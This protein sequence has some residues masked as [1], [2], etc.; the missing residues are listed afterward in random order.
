MPTQKPVL[1]KENSIIDY[2]DFSPVQPHN[3]AVT[4]SV[5]IQ[6][7]NPITT[8]L[9]STLSKFQKNAYGGTFVKD[10]QMVLCGD[11]E[12]CVKLF[13]TS[14]KENLRTFKGH[15]AGVHRAFFTL[16]KKHIASFSDDKSVRLW[17]VESA[18][19]VTKFNDAHT[20][21]IRAG[22]VSPVSPDILLSGGY[23]DI[24][25]MYD[26]R[27]NST[28]FE[29]NHGSRIHSVMFLPTGGIFISCGA[30]HVKLWDAFAGGRL[31][32]VMATHSKDI[33]CVRLACHGR[34]LLSGG[35]DRKVK[36]YDTSTYQ[37]V[38]SLDFPNGITSMA[39]APD[40]ETLVVGMT[41][42][43]VSVQRMDSDRK[44]KTLERKAPKFESPREQI[45]EDHKP[46]VEAQYNKNLRKYCY[47]EALDDV[48]N[49]LCTNRTPHITVG[50]MAELIRRKGLERALKG[51][52]DEFLIKFIAFVIRYIGDSR[53]IKTLINVANVMLDAYENEISNLSA[54]IAKK[55]NELSKALRREQNL[56]IECMELQGAFGM[57]YSGASVAEPS[58]QMM[59]Y[60]RELNQMQP[61]E[62]A[63]EELIVRVDE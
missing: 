34:R 53:F 60:K 59:N 3:F 10:G 44:I 40:D 20:D 1:I 6:I 4:C 35:L 5:R 63:K 33:T 46:T 9:T 41:D 37:T 27:T 39:I 42:G 50:V 23:D 30:S 62:S 31:M 25:K 11:E 26:T 45:I 19:C 47:A 56:L 38:H 8:D 57:L 22:C 7:Y 17:N 24:V 14:T 16:D 36:I 32:A 52:P 12:G 55:F 54:P 28:V 58:S 13:Q 21:Y 43:M 61:S 49:A 2:V 29:V 48:F 51:Q 18:E 15:T